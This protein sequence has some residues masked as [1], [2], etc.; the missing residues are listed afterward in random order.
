MKESSDA[1]SIA[2]SYKNTKNYV[3]E[4]ALDDFFAI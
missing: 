3:F 1:I 2:S 4:D